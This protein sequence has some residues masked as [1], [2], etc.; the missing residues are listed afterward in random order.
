[1]IYNRFNFNQLNSNRLKGDFKTVIN[2]VISGDQIKS[3]EILVLTN[4]ITV[5]LFVSNLK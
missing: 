1:M 4:Q 3:H 2:G 5:D